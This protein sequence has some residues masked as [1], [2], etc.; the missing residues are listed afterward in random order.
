M[1]GLGLEPGAAGW[2]AQKNPQGYGSTQ[3]SIPI[4]LSQS[5]LSSSPVANLIKPLQS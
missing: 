1:V 5:F 3:I 2:K 4:Y